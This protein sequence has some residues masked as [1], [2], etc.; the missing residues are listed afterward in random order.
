MV[1]VTKDA[2]RFWGETPRNPFGRRRSIQGAQPAYAKTLGLESGQGRLRRDPAPILH[3][4]A[5]PGELPLGVTARVHDRAGGR[6]VE[7]YLAVE[8]ANE[9]GHA[10]RLHCRQ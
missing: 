6:F 2:S 10:M 5:E 4:V 1:M 9:P 7:R 8:M 3:L